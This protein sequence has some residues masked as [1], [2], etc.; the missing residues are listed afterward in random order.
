[1]IWWV[2]FRRVE[3]PIRLN[4]LKIAFGA[5]GDFFWE[6]MSRLGVELLV[7]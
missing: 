4:A 2:F 3:I 7:C 5:D 1:V 6:G